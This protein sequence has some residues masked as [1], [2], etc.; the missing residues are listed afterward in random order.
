MSRLIATALVSLALLGGPA[1]AAPNTRAT[2]T[3][4]SHRYTPSPIYLAG[5][6]PVRL[7]L[8]NRA[9]KTHDFT[10]PAFFRASRLLRGHAPGGEVRLGAGRSAV[11]DLV[12]VRGT[13]KVHCGEFG[14]K[15]LGM[16]TMIIVL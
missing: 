5:G 13:Y 9:G 3:L 16:S 11:I 7:V 6:V 15:M 4:T 12:P 10:A 1:I 2:V 14:H 8:I